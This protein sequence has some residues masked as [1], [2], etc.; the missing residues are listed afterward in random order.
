ML[1]CT[2]NDNL[3]TWPQRLPT[4]MAAYRMT[5]H[6]V[7]GIMSN[8]AMLG[9]ELLLP[10]TLVAKPPEEPMQATVLLS[11]ICMMPCKQQILRFAKQQNLWPG[12]KNSTTMNVPEKQNLYKVSLYGF[13]GLRH[14]FVNSTGSYSSYGWDPGA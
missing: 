10:A 1:R 9:R 14:Q 3:A 8:M 2:A 11:K 13:T 5:V 6:R 12:Q 4:V 7:T